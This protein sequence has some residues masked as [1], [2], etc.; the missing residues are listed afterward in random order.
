MFSRWPIKQKLWLSGLV[1]FLIFAVLAA[2]GLQGGYAYRQLAKSISYDRAIELKLAAD[3][4]LEV[5]DLR[6]TFSS[7]RRRMNAF[8]ESA[9]EPIF[10]REQFRNDLSSVEEALRQYQHQLMLHTPPRE[11]AGERPEFETVRKIEQQLSVLSNI[12]SEEA[13]VFNDL[14]IDTIDAQ[15]ETLQRLA[16]QLPIHLQRRM[17]E[18]AGEVRG[19]YRVWIGS[20]WTATIVSLVVFVGLGLLIN[21]WF[22][23]P[24]KSLVEGSRRVAAGNFDYRISIGT[25]D[26]VAELADAMNQMTHS[27]QEIKNNLDNAVQ[28]RTKEVVQSERLASVGFLAA[29]VAHEINNPLASIAMR[30]ESLESRLQHILAAD[31]AKDDGHHDPEVAVLRKY[32]KVIQDEAF[33]CKGIT[34]KLLDFSRMGDVEKQEVDLKEVI[35]DVIEMVQHLGKYRQKTIHFA[36]S[37]RVVASVNP[38]EMKQ[39]VLNLITNALDNMDPGGTVALELQQTRGCAEIIVADDG[40]GMTAE[41]LEHLFEPFFTRRRDGSGTGLGLSI[42]FRIIQDHGGQI[43]ATSEGPGRGSVFTVSLPMG[44]AIKHERHQQLQ[45]A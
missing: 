17:Q 23:Q 37:R 4:S 6:A 33:R 7:A 31:E 11:S 45:V 42:T 12:A 34:E 39:V 30:A 19:R 38:Q 28:Q 41:V 5:G 20:A 15:L 1:L 36:A 3:I 40:C 26:E 27:F 10:L 16:G 25:H 18:F 9:D 43:R 13:W 8:D 29:G 21:K 32:L 44:K 35:E 2:V 14:P 22:F 24:L